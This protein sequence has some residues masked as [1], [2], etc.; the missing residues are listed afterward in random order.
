MN[1][2][3]CEKICC[4]SFFK[5]K[6]ILL[7]NRPTIRV[8]LPVKPLVLQEDII[9]CKYSVSNCNNHSLTGVK[10]LFM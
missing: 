5:K 3:V 9:F 1:I 10:S 6:T 7:G 8:D 2:L 4:M